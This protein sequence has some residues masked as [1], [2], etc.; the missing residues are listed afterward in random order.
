MMM[1]TVLVAGLTLVGGSAAAAE[2]SFDLPPFTGIDISSG[3]DAVVSVGGAQS[4][5]AESPNQD[6]LDELVVEVRD[7]TLTAGTDWNLLDLL[8]FGDRQI[9][10]HVTVPSLERASSSSGA[11]VQVTG[12]TADTA[13][14]NASSGADLDLVGAAAAHFDIDVSSGAD[15]NVEG[16]CETA[17][18]GS[19]SGATLR[20]ER[21]TCAEVEIDVSSG[22]DADVFASDAVT[23]NASSGGD[24]IVHGNPPA[25]EQE[26]SSGGEV[27]IRN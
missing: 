14:L 20:A 16:S 11:N 17:N 19:S 1:A 25:V 24:I 8:F 5:R 6:Q 10:L 18:A 26:A 4:V 15:L 23:A 22:A 21:L 9:K 12:L 3:I 2:A 7:G 13:V 27:D